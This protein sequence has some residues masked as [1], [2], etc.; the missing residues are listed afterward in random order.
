MIEIRILSVRR[1]PANQAGILNI[2]RTQ[3]ATGRS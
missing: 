3:K 1:V 2:T